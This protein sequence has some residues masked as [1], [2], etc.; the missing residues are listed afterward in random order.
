MAGAFQS[1]PR[2]TRLL[3]GTAN[4]TVMTQS[5]VD[6]SV[7]SCSYN[8]VPTGAFEVS[9]IATGTDGVIWA[10]TGCDL[11]FLPPGDG[12]GALINWG[13]YQFCSSSSDKATD[14]LVN[15]DN[16]IISTGANGVYVIEYNLS[17]NQSQIGIQGITRWDSGNFLASNRITDLQMMGNQLLISTENAG[18]SR[19]DHGNIDVAFKVVYWEYACIQQCP[20]NIGV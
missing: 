1:I 12:G 4:G 14:I 2:R 20:W 15:A 13:G 17:S 9:A 3:V 5:L 19:R 10:V 7:G 11:R 18:I 6:S 16:V 8:P